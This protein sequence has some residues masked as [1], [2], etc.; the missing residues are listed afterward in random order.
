MTGFSWWVDGDLDEGSFGSSQRLLEQ[1]RTDVT[2]SFDQQID[3]ACSPTDVA[4][5]PYWLIEDGTLQVDK[6][7]TRSSI[8]ASNG[9]RWFLDRYLRN[10]YWRFGVRPSTFRLHNDLQPEDNGSQL[11]SNGVMAFSLSVM[12]PIENT[13]G[14]LRA[15]NFATGWIFQ[16]VGLPDSFGNKVI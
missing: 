12:G 16:N 2:G 13:R 3:V 10:W 4:A 15:G 6:A 8:Y 5:W 7:E 9:R 1:G 14:G 11:A